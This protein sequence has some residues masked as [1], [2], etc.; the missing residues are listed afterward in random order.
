MHFAIQHALIPG[1]DRTTAMSAAAAQ[2]LAPM[3]R[4]RGKNALN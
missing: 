2:A 4:N 3:L 1:R